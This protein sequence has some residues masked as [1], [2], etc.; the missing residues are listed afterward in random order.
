MVLLLMIELERLFDNGV[1]S[2]KVLI[3]SKFVLANRY[4]LYF[5]VDDP[6]DPETA[7]FARFKYRKIKD[8]TF[9]TIYDLKWYLI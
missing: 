6:N 2:D 9:L 7:M 5:L 4:V 8:Y 3:T 1:S